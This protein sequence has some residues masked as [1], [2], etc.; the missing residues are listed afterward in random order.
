ATFLEDICLF[1]PLSLFGRCHHCS[2]F[3]C[4]VT[5]MF[6][7]KIFTATALPV[8]RSLA[9]APFAAFRVR[10]GG[11]P[12][13]DLRAFV[14]CLIP[15]VPNVVHQITQTIALFYI[16]PGVYAIFTRSSVI[17]TAL[18][19]LIFFPEERHILRQWQFQMGTLLGLL[20][21]IGVFWFQPRATSGPV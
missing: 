14:L 5:T 6:G 7:R 18:L 3:P 21:A 9:I 1:S 2:N 11:G 10:R 12:R 20:G 16:G 17:I 13:L 8:L 4:C 19:A 15:A